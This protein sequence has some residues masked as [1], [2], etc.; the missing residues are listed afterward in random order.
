MSIHF[1]AARVGLLLIALAGA[2]CSKDEP[3]PA[4]PAAVAP[5]ASISAKSYHVAETFNVGE[6][7]YVRSMAA[8]EGKGSLWVG[9]SVG[10][11]EVDLASHDMRASYTRAE[12]LANEYVFGMLVDHNGNRWFGTNGGGVSRLASDGQ[13]KT[14]FPMH[15]LADYWVYSFAE[16]SDGTLWIGTWAGL[17]R[18]DAKTGAF[19]N[20]VTELVNEWVYGLDVDSKDRVWIGTEGGINMFD[21]KQWFTWTHADG[22]GAPN[23]GNLPISTNTGLGTRSRHDLNV[24]EEGRE[25]Y[26]PNYVFTLIIDA[27]DGVWAGTWGGGVAH[28]DGAKWTNYTTQDGL[29]GNIVYSAAQDKDG[30]LWFGTN[31]G[32]SH[33]DGKNWQTYT[34]QDG[35][36]ENNAYAIVPAGDGQVWVG[37]RSGVVLL[38]K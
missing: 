36:L 11:L 34:S 27:N 7:V 19:Q 22:L 31:G 9:T 3:A 17:S 25:T 33:F 23:A 20:Y 13:W 29:A 28:Y 38:S 21:G 26:N 18:L 4:E 6:N 1:A 37:T 14:F 12:G 35:L 10:V 5:A 30:G 15:G 24:L 8:D 32:L 2:G 16:Q